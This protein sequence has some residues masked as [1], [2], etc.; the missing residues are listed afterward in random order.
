MSEEGVASNR[1]RFDRA[2]ALLDE[3]RGKVTA[4]LSTIAQAQADR[5]PAEAEW[6]LGEIAHHLAL[7]EREYIGIVADLAAKAAPHQFDYEKVL[8]SRP[9]RIE[10]T[11]D[12]AITGR[13]ST[14]PELL[15]TS[16]KPLAELLQDLQDSHADA[17]GVLAPYRDEDLSV[18][19]FVH[20]RLG[21]MTLYERIAQIAYH[22][23]KHLKQ[24]ERTLARIPPTP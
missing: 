4:L 9:F 13:L 17:R 6:S 24:M 3:V 23:M 7:T 19:F 16:G 15:P 22:E 11:W 8:R 14:P 20:P 1:E 2:L 18:K 21:T 12:I 5:R 10:D